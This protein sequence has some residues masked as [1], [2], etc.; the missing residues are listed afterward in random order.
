MSVWTLWRREQSCTAGNR[1]RSPLVHQLR[2]SDCWVLY[3]NIFRAYFLFLSRIKINIFQ[4]LAWTIMS[5]EA[6]WAPQP[7]GGGDV[8][9]YRW[10]KVGT[11]RPTLPELFW[12]NNIQTWHKNEEIWWGSVEPSLEWG[13][14]IEQRYFTIFILSHSCLRD[15]LIGL[16]TEN[17]GKWQVTQ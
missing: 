11:C 4:F 17:I 3:K 5:R 6:S 1:T 16:Y 9:A 14:L 10:L 12:L 7:E 13:C 2:Y 8:Y 15:F